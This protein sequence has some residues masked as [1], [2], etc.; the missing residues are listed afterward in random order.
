M[1]R[2]IRKQVVNVLIGVVL[3]LLV[4]W[5]FGIIKMPEK[6]MKQ[7]IQK[8]DILLHR[9]F[10]LFPN[11]NDVVV[12]RSNYFLREDSLDDK[13]YLFIQ[14]IVALPG[15]TI[16]IDSG[17]VFIN[18]LLEKPNAFYQRNYIVQLK[19]SIEKFS[20]LNESISEKVMISK[21]FEYAMSLSYQQYQALVNDTNVLS[22]ESQLDHPSI[23]EENVYPYSED[24]RWNKHFFGPLYL[25][26]KKDKI[27][28]TKKNL[29]VYFPIIQG[30][31]KFS[32][33]RN[34]SLFINKKY[35]N[36]YVFKNDYYFVLGDNR[37][38]AIDSRFLG[39]IKR[40]D[41]LGIV[42]YHFH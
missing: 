5:N 39:P 18:S 11:H 36:E 8:G 1:I 40:K 23:F 41:I 31:E 17:N 2:K 16:K 14:R 6:D 19:D 9:K 13:R 27:T 12:Y 42:F 21:K 28:L 24:I 20:Y 34:D 25:P 3:F 35:V 26:K 15:D 30:E 37:D 38:N 4:Y 7:N 29:Y 32:E 22:I 33:M 10:L